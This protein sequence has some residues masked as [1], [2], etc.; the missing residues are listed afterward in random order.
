MRRAFSVLNAAG[1]QPFI[2]DTDG[3]YN[4]ISSLPLAG[5]IELSGVRSLHSALLRACFLTD[6]SSLHA[7]RLDR[8]SGVPICLR[9]SGIPRIL[10]NP[11]P[12]LLLLS[13]PC[14]YRP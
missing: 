9:F 2:Q 14:V 10:L 3:Q 8:F 11:A 7:H 1:C 4:S 6:R 13:Y 12:R 5:K